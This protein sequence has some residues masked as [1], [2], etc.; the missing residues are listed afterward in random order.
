MKRDTFFI[1]LILIMVFINGCRQQEKISLS[2][3]LP[4]T[5]KLSDVVDAG[6]TVEQK[7]GE[8]QANCRNNKLIDNSGKEIFFY[9]RIG[10]WGNAPVN[11]QEILDQQREAINTLKEQGTVI[12]MSC[13]PTGL[14]IP[15]AGKTQN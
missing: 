2:Q 5:I 14:L 13:N 15:S 6:A 8:L 4:P 12:E 1:A 9:K 3:C 10:C 7:L 11:H